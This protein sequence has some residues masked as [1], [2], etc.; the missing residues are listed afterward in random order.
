MDLVEERHYDEID[1]VEQVASE[2]LDKLRGKQSRT[3][4]R[5]KGTV[6]L[7]RKSTF[8]KESRLKDMIIDLARAK[9]APRENLKGFIIIALSFL[10]A[11]LTCVLWLKSAAI[12]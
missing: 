11:P 6:R 7:H 5:L 3:T 1:R 2:D 4:Q 10:V 9:K 8:D 12:C